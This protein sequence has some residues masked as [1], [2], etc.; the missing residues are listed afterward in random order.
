MSLYG[1]EFLDDAKEIT[2]DL[3]IPCSTAGSTVTFS[4]LISEPAYTS[5]LEAGGFVERTQYT[6]RL[7][8]ATASWTKPDGSN[9][10]SAAVIAS[11][12]PIPALGIG[13]KLTVG[14]KVVRITSQTYKTLS[15]WI[16]LVVVDDNQ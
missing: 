11:G 3:G 6:V 13:K 8:A 10:A 7:P 12:V 2:F 16:T 14:G 9:G 1:Q 4:A 5:G 15:A